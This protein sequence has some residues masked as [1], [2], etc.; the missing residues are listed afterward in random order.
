MGT[1]QSGGLMSAVERSTE[2][3]RSGSKGAVYEDGIYTSYS[4][5]GFT[6]YG[7]IGLIVAVLL[8]RCKR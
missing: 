3:V 8:G 1:I 2:G 6:Q 4:P 5:Y 7:E